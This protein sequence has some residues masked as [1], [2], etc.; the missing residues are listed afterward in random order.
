[1][2]KRE[3][4]EEQN[5]GVDEK[6]E[7]DK[8]HGIITD[9]ERFPLNGKSAEE[10]D[11]YFQK[12]DWPNDKVRWK[13]SFKKYLKRNQNHEVVHEKITDELDHQLLKF[14]QV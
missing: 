13:Q 3:R 2:L 6:F 12:G 8:K 11:E 7:W 5:A 14:E 4:R 9:A 1:M 10:I